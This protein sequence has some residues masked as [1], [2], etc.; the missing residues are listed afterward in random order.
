MLKENLIEIISGQ[1]PDLSKSETKIA[2]VILDDPENVTTS[3]IA[4]LAKAADVSEPSVNRFC[5]RFEA[6]GFPDFK[7]KLAQSLVSNQ[8]YTH[9]S[10]NPDDDVH[11]YTPKI[12]DSTITQLARVRDNLSHAR[13]NQVVDKLI[14]AKRIFF[15]GVGASGP[16]ASDAENK[17]FRFNLPVAYHSDLVMTRMCASTGS[18]GDVFFFISHTGRTKTV[19]DI[20]EIAKG[21]GATVI[22]LTAPDSPLANVSTLSIDVDIQEDTDEY[23]PMDSRIVHLVILDDLATGVTLRRGS[24]FWPHLGKIRDIIKP[25]RFLKKE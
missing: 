17:F 6:S 15:F 7:L 22:C 24:D 19:V 9:R 23:M 21:N 20:A 4:T 16:V 5:K 8:H 3:S 2:R 12:F 25:T 14:Q 10:V 13:I 18:T 1:L 11:A